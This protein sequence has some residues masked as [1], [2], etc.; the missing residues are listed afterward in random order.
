M[1]TCKVWGSPF[2]GY[3]PPAYTLP[4]QPLAS[5]PP[6]LSFS[7][8]K[9]GDVNGSASIV[10]TLQ[11][12]A[13]TRGSE[14]L[15][16]MPDLEMKAGETREIS[17]QASESGAWEGFQF[18]LNYDPA[19]LDIEAVLPGSVLPVLPEH[20]AIPQPGVLNVSWSDAQAT[21]VLRG[22]TWLRLKV[23]AL[24][25]VS[26]SEAIYGTK[27]GLL[28]AEAYDENGLEHP[29]SWRFSKTESLPE[30]G[31]A[32][33]FTPMPNPSTGASRIPLRLN[34]AENV[35]VEITDLRGNLIWR[36]ASSLTAG[37]HFL[38]IPASAMDASGIYIWR[39]FAGE[40]FKSGRLV[41]I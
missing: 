18:S 5:Y 14:I 40:T 1:D 30:T 22:D 15:L 2:F 12:V 29:L 4:V 35:S 32:Q 13:Q 37:A 7:G 38:D 31:S 17:V 34:A 8:V 26:L 36:Q 11:G 24:A 23:K 33:I 9:M 10:D 25:G 41:R 20:W 6:N 21:P 19:L 27:R 28:Q 16:E 3:C 39:V